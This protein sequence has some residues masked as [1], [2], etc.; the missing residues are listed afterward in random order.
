MNEIVNEVVAVF[1][2]VFPLRYKDALIEKIKGDA[3]STEE[4]D[5]NN[6]PAIPVPDYPLMEG[7]MEKRG[8]VVKNWKS[9][10][11]VALNKA[12]NFV[13]NYSE[14]EGGKI[15]GTVNCCGY[16]ARKFDED[17]TKEFGEFGIKLV[18]DNQRR[19]TWMF[20]CADEEQLEEWLRCFNNACNKAKPPVNKDEVLAAAFEGAYRAVRWN[21]GYYG[22]YS[23][24][25]TEAET[26]GGL[27]CDILDR[28]LINDV[29]R[30][31]P[32]GPARNTICDVVHKTVDTAVVAAVSACWNS[33]V[34]LCDGL[35]E[36][37]E[38][39]IK[40]L[41]TP[42]FEQE[43]AIKEK[44]VTSISDTVNPFLA[45][46]GGRICRPLLAV[47][48]KSV[49]NG[50]CAAIKGYSEMM[51]KK[52]KNGNFEEAKFADSSRT[53]DRSIEYWGGPL[54]KANRIAWSIYSSDL[55]DVAALFSNGF[56]PYSVYS[57]TLDSI[58]DLCHRA[59]Y[60]FAT[61]A[62]ESGYAGLETIFSEVVAD[63]VHDAKIAEAALLNQILSSILMPS[64]ES[65]VIVPCGELVQPV[66]DLIDA[67][68]V[69]GLSGLFN[70]PSLVEEVI[71]TII[72]G[73]VSAI[74]EG[75][76]SDIDTQ[77]N[78]CGV[79]IAA[80]EIS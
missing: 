70:L 71:G 66:Q 15:K 34:G 25:G 80:L 5:P 79:E 32:A 11:F 74:V 31:I 78:E 36:T 61:K 68:P 37:L 62:I 77:I 53:A 33:V 4:E 40:G 17:D 57:V 3:T 73:G 65:N 45:D 46:V 35:R 42:L 51:K 50:M 63:M 30:D 56:S 48:A 14:K 13:I 26:L 8:D 9:R 44:V 47:T 23:I 10:H 29:I 12:D 64:I 75:S 21:Y 76:V 43:V 28:E 16:R 19:R 38:M 58:R 2:K 59:H 67:I 60:K 39:S 69:P 24:G 22:W 18:P 7:I 6:L 54:D 20:K 55:N 49:T 27:T 1:A 41:L 52:I 72:E